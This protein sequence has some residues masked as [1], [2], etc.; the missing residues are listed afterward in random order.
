M[1]GFLDSRKRKL[2]LLPAGCKR[3]LQLLQVCARTVPVC[4]GELERSAQSKGWSLRLRC[5]PLWVSRQ[6]RRPKSSTSTR[7]IG[8]RSPTR[9]HADTPI[10][11]PTTPGFVAP[12]WAKDFSLGR[13]PSN[14]R[15]SHQALK[16]FQKKLR[17]AAERG[18]K[19]AFLRP[20][21]AGRILDAFPG[22]SPQA[23]VFR[24]FQG[25]RSP[26]RRHADTPIRFSTT[27]S[28]VQRSRT[29]TIGNR[30]PTRRYADTPIRFSPRGRFKRI[31]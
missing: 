5:F 21:R 8:N 20:Y 6:A 12:K 11:F 23:F 4:S 1:N 18:R 29:R 10:R 25:V 22:A 3:K 14:P 19:L 16:A 30:S 28:D 2:Q 13:S 9:R 27:A 24:P 26:T 7:T 31:P 15:K 17:A